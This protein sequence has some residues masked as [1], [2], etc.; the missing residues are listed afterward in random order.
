MSR[1]VSRPDPD[2]LGV[3]VAEFLESIQQ[4]RGFSA[5]TIAAYRNDL[6]Q[7][8]AYLA[9][10]PAE[11]QLAPVMAWSDVTPDHLQ[12]FA[13]HLRERGYANST[14]ARKTAAIKSLSH[15]L[16]TTGVL[17]V[18]PAEAL[19]SPRVDKVAPRSITPDQVDALFRQAA[20]D[21]RPEGMRDFAM[22]QTLYS[23]GVRVSE[24]IAL[25]LGDLDLEGGRLACTGKGGNRRDLPL[26][27]SAVE[28]L[29]RYLEEGR[30]ALRPVDDGALF[31]N[32]RG[33]RLTRQGFWLILKT[34]AQRAGIG[35]VT[36]HT[37][38]H[39]FAAHALGDGADIKD[40]QRLLGHVSIST[41]QVYR[42]TP[43]QVPVEG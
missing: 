38:R 25:D 13:L 22:L 5:N 21:D 8:V 23:S 43:G 37:L 26:R 24:L 42:R 6:S 34:Y 32:H 29:H 36:P 16:A 40:L 11:D 1:G 30:P 14:V 17:P 3:A 18:D 31:V 12:R 35:E 39:S 7:F 28:A 10:P 2:P 33:H 27:H 15:H 20:G 4:G 9:A 19:A 41:T